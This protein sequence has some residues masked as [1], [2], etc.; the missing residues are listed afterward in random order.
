[1]LKNLYQVRAYNIKH[2]YD[3]KDF[4]EAYRLILQKAIDEIWNKIIWI[5]RYLKGRRG[6]IPKI[7]KDNNFKHHY[8]RNLLMKDWNY[9]KHYVDSAINLYLQMEG[10]SPSPKLFNELMKRWSG[11]TLTGEEAYESFDE[12]ERSL[13]LMNPK[14]YLRLK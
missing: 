14:S 10:L 6:L 12:L 7:P 4:L 3:I 13:R 8:L 9:S 5:E 11:F 2:D 1:M